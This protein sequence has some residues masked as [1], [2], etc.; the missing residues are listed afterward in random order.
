MGAG[1]II[2][3]LA[4]AP[5]LAGL[6]IDYECVVDGRTVTRTM[7][8]DGWFADAAEHPWQVALFQGASFAC[9]GVLLSAEWVLTQ[10]QCVA[11]V[12]PFD[13]HVGYGEGDLL[14]IGW[15]ERYGVWDVFVHPEYDPAA[16]AMN[17]V[18]LLRLADP[19]VRDRYSHVAV[20]HVDAVDD[21]TQYQFTG[22]VERI[23][24]NFPLPA[25]ER[26]LA[27]FPSA[28]QGFHA[29]N[30]SECVDYLGAALL[31]KPRVAEF[32][33]SR[34]R[35]SNDNALAE[36]KNG[37]VIRKRSVVGRS[38]GRTPRAWAASTARS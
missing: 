6:A 9:G 34:P 26:L 8:T 19:G 20:Y 16:T 1:L 7:S 37:S 24:E 15:A 25:L 28:V 18:A 14:N 13:L 32:T 10:G 21:V 31:E 38:L 33:K 30:P 17:D 22:C 35:P 29:H 36:S 23:S 11:D 2:G 4:V 5:L 3:F 27:P 12:D